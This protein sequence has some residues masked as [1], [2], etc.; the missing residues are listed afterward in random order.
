MSVFDD[1]DSMEIF[2][3]GAGSVSGGVLCESNLDHRVAMSFLCLGL[4]SKN[5]ITVLHCN[6]AYPTNSIRGCESSSNGDN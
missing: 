3:N 6:S 5:K 4:A 2:G 1:K